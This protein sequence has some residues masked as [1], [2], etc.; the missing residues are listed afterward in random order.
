VADDVELEHLEVSPDVTA[1]VEGP[2]VV[3]RR[4]TRVLARRST[5]V[6][7]FLGV[8]VI[9]AIVVFAARTQRH[10]AAHHPVSLFLLPQPAGIPAGVTLQVAG[11]QPV[12]TLLTYFNRDKCHGGVEIDLHMLGGPPGGSGQPYSQSPITATTVPC[13]AAD[14]GS[15]PQQVPAYS[16]TWGDTNGSVIVLTTAGPGVL[17]RFVNSLHAAQRSDWITVARAAPVR[18][19]RDGELGATGAAPAPLDDALCTIGHTADLIGPDGL[20]ALADAITDP[21]RAQAALAANK[22][23]LLARHPEVLSATVGP[24]LR[25]A[26]TTTS[27]GRVSVVEVADYAIILHLRTAE[28]CPRGQPFTMFIDGVPV[29]YSTG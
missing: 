7:A 21:A 1:Q 17:A 9:T 8:L 23:Q 24:G 4:P 16:M 26:W 22:D 6:V 3:G 29:L 18:V 11:L 5:Q 19:S 20:P 2:P 10:E 12:E 13:A 14:T 28:D 25:R 15:P 27:D